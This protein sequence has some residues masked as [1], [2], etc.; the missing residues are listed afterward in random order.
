MNSFN[1][2]GKLKEFNRIKIA[3]VDSLANEAVNFFKID[4]FEAEGFIDQGVKR[5][6]KRKP[7]TKRNSGR[8]LMVDT[9]RLRQ[10]GRVLR[11]V[12]GVSARVGYPV[13]YA[14][15]HNEGSKD[16]PKRQLVGTSYE[17]D[18]RSNRVI[19][20]KMGNLL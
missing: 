20:A 19:R 9:G 4:V 3:I 17:L 12:P 13:H 8:R 1:L 11:K 10:S 16:L 2:G 15:Y 14:G 7:G 18:R 5:W 6:P